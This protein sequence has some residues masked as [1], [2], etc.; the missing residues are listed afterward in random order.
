[1]ISITVIVVAIAV[2]P[3]LDV[4]LAIQPIQHPQH[5]NMIVTNS[6]NVVP[7]DVANSSMMM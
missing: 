3:F 5:D 6:S 4:D 7:V 1:M 2:N